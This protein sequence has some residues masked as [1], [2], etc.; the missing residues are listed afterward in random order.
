MREHLCG[1]PSGAPRRVGCAGGVGTR[2]LLC[3]NLR[4]S[5]ESHKPAT[6]IFCRARIPLGFVGI[7]KKLHTSQGRVELFG[8]FSSPGFLFRK[9]EGLLT[10][11]EGFHDSTIAL[12]VAVLQVVEEGTTLTYEFHESTFGR[13]IFTVGSHV[14]RQVGNTV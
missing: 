8:L 2:W 4:I 3:A 14:F 7:Q 10:Q 13:M 1:R 6:G 9:A 5:F 11:A 12:D